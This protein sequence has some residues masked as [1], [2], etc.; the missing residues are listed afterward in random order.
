MK[1]IIALGAI[2]LIAAACSSQQSAS[3]PAQPAQNTVSPQP[4]DQGIVLDNKVVTNT[5]VQG[6]NN[7]FTNSTIGLEV[8]YPVG[9]C[10]TPSNFNFD[11]YAVD[12][13]F[14]NSTAACAEIQAHGGVFNDGQLRIEEQ[15][16]DINFGSINTR[17]IDE[18]K[19]SAGKVKG[20]A[21]MS[22][23]VAGAKFDAECKYTKL[24]ELQ[25]CNS[26]LE[27]FKFNPTAVYRES[28]TVYKPDPGA[29]PVLTY[30]DSKYQFSLQY[31]K[32][33]YYAIP[34][35][36]VPPTDN[37]D[38]Y[39]L[40]NKLDPRLKKYTYIPS[41]GYWDLMGFTQPSNTVEVL[42]FFDGNGPLNLSPFQSLGNSLETDAITHG[43]GS[44]ESVGTG[45]Y[46]TSLII[47][48]FPS[49]GDPSGCQSGSDPNDFV[50]CGKHGYNFEFLV[51]DNSA[52]VK[53][54]INSFNP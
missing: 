54:I 7:V 40:K 39:S 18:P 43:K 32:N 20:V 27:S 50:V 36:V 52:A 17:H 41:Q 8:S 6:S 24:S 19:S 15:T 47:Y 25:A 45:P 10:L 35:N 51:R 5:V 34:A 22:F 12:L 9:W 49:D 1:K 30:Q 29:K 16:T 33:L 3:V 28:H 53:Q 23:T 48:V 2:L 31:P 42:E 4:Q 46:D 21:D 26:I 37:S 44:S 13:S 14:M 11:N 38:S